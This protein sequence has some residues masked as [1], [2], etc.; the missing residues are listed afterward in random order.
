MLYFSFL[1]GLL[2]DNF[3]TNLTDFPPQVGGQ[4]SQ[5]INQEADAAAEVGP[6]LFGASPLQR[7]IEGRHGMQMDEELIELWKLLRWTRVK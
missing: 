4:H 3:E 1:C 5:P 6:L 7:P 2:F